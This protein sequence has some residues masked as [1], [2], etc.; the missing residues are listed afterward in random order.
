VTDVGGS[1]D[2]EIT[3]GN[4]AGF[5]ANAINEGTS[6]RQALADWR[7]LG[8]TSADA[9]WYRMYGQVTDTLLRT[10]DLA[11]LDPAA[12]PSAA[13]YGEWAMGQGGEFATQV[14]VMVTDINDGTTTLLD[15]THI[16]VDPHTPEDAMAAAILDYG[17]S[18]TLSLYDQSLQG[19]FV[20]HVWQTVPWNG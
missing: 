16:T 18:D 3:P 19:A 17:Y 9:Q 4:P 7:D 20:T 10:G 2:I 13:D 8:G 1:G 12:L 15:Y 6:A 5:I 11:A 14:K